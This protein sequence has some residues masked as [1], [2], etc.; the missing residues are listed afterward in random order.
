VAAESFINFGW[1][2]PI[3]I[4]IPLGIFFDYFQHTFLA[5]DSGWVLNAVGIALIPSFLSMEHQLTQ[6]LGGIVQCVAMILLVLWPVLRVRARQGESAPLSDV[7]P[8][9][10]GGLRMPVAMPRRFL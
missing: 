4:M 7:A 2:G 5:R 1:L 10:A 8:R 9:V 6:Y 3:L